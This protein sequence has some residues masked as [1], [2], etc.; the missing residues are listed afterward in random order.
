MDAQ[1]PRCQDGWE[2]PTHNPAG[3][4]AYSENGRGR[5]LAALRHTA[6]CFLFALRRSVVRKS[7]LSNY[8]IFQ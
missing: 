6:S 8:H 5:K 4:L 2:R 7:Q 1:M 3:S